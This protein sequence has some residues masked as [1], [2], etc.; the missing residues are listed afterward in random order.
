[1]EIIWF[2][3][4]LQIILEY[5]YCK[6]RSFA[7]TGNNVLES[8]WCWVARIQF[9]HRWNKRPKEAFIAE[10]GSNTPAISVS[11]TFSCTWSVP[12]Q[13]MP[14]FKT[15]CTYGRVQLIIVSLT[16]TLWHCDTMTLWHYDTVTRRWRCDCK[17]FIIFLL[18]K[19]RQTQ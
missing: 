3:F 15:F 6:L 16:V 1:M 18:D 7:H 9:L 4:S 11:K 10:I 8:T 19:R 14:V 2:F 5:P 17:D 12:G 13:L